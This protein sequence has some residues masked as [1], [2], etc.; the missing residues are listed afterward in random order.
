MRKTLSCSAVFL[1]LFFA[2]GTPGASAQTTEEIRAAQQA[3]KGKGL[4]PGPIDG[5]DGPKTREAVRQFQK[6]QNLQADGQLG[7]QTLDS[8]GVTH[9]TAGTNMHEAGTNLKT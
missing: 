1:G 9:G 8:L 4:D 7:P 6:Q 3:L 5:V 2:F